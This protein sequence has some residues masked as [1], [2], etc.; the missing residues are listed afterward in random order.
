[1]GSLRAPAK[2]LMIN[3]QYKYRQHAVMQLHLQDA[4][5]PPLRNVPSLSSFCRYGG[6]NTLFILQTSSVFP[7]R[8][9]L[10]R[11]CMFICDIIGQRGKWKIAYCSQLYRRLRKPVWEK[12]SRI[13]RNERRLKSSMAE[14]VQAFHDQTRAQTPSPTTSERLNNLDKSPKQLDVLFPSWKVNGKIKFNK[15]PRVTS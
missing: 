6:T 11:V 8:I 13:S 2:L 10:K 5:F 14:Q 4:L 15:V 12:F 7:W 9:T 3:I 1:M